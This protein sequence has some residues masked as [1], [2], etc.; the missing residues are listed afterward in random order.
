MRQDAY[1]D[2]DG[3][4]L[5]GAPS[6]SWLKILAIVVPGVIFVAV[7]VAATLTTGGAPRPGDTAPGFS[8]PLLSGDGELALEDL[9]G[10]PVVLNFWASW[11]VPCEDEAP[12]LREAAEKWSGEVEFVGIDIRDARSEALAFVD[13]HGL[14]FAHVRDETL[15][16]Y[17]DYGLTGQP[18]SFF[19]DADGVIVEHVAGPLTESQLQRLLDILVARDG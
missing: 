19:I 1:V 11:C 12:L 14:E 4:S 17:D 8:A 5:E 2:T 3:F 15:Q 9:A 10:T 18:E 16:I 13:R 7:L 6:R